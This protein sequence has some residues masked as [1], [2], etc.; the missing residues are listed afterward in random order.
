MMIPQAD[1]QQRLLVNLILEMN[2]DKKPLPRFWYLPRGL[3]AAVIMTGDDHAN[4]G[5]EGRFNSFLASSP[6]GCSVRD[7]ECIR[8]TSYIFSTI[9]TQSLTSLE[10]ASFNA[11]GFEVGLHVNTNCADYNQAQ[12]ETFYTD[13]INTWTSKYTNI[14]API[15]QRHH[16]IVWSD[17]VTGAKVQLNHGIRFDTSYYFW[18]PSWVVNRPGFFSGTGMPMRFVDLDGSMIDVY[19]ATSQMTDESG[20]AYPYTINT[21]LDNAL[22]STKGYFGAFTINAHTDLATITESTETV[23]SAL[24]RNVPVITSRQMLDWLDFRNRS[25][26]SSISWSGNTLSFTVNQDE[27]NANVPGQ[28]KGLQTL[29]PIK[30][31]VGFISNLTLN[32][33]V[34]PFTTTNI[35]G[36]DYV[37]FAANAG[38]YVATYTAD[39]TPPTLTGV[40]PAVNAINIS[41]TSVVTATFSEA[42][43]VSTI[44]STTFELRNASNLLVP[45]T[46]SYNPISRTATLQPDS[47]LAASSGYTAIIKGGATDPRVKDS[48]GNALLSDNIWSFTTGALPCSTSCSV[49]SSSTNPPMVADGQSVELGVKFKSSISGKVTGIRFYNSNSPISGAF[50]ASLWN[51]SGGTPLATGTVTST[52]GGWRQVDFN[53]PVDIA[54]NTVYVAS[55]HVPATASGYAATS[56]GF[57]TAID[58]API[59]L[60]QDG[61]NGGNGV[62]A[63]S[64]STVFPSDTFQATNYWVDVVFTTNVGPDTFPPVVTGQTPAINAT[65]IPVSSAVTATFSESMDALTINTNTFELR[66]PAPANALVPASV[67][68]NTNTRTVTLTPN[69]PLAES[70]LYTATVKGGNADPRVKDS[71]G[72]ALAADFSWSFTT[73]SINTTGCSGNT[74]SIWPNNPTPTIITD[75]DTASVELGVKFRSSTDGIYL[76]NS[77]LQR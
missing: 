14:P 73:G 11:Q 37:A 20:Q 62:Y 76:R 34:V 38:S 49:F 44:N 42:M 27:A 58:S 66:G 21:L 69:S 15:T 74:E 13:Q 7:W 23:S 57:N 53:Q 63:Y 10:A 75:S 40:S 32:G 31:N 51:I 5:T 64:S 54:A 68:Y 77:I 71:A 72:N 48:S 16:C 24:T 25:F 29:L 60:L 70:S 61:A 41:P 18:P 55:Y 50:S 47:L 65:G 6:A 17:W 39:T 46:V 8:G 28:G 35:K 2:K 45:S 19:Q 67:S 12:L 1:E 26:F 33:N 9:D 43:D 36:V 3:K 4:N 56:G 52:N 30:A 59:Q 22:D